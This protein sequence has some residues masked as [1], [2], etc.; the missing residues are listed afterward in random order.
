MTSDYPYMCEDLRLRVGLEGE[1]RSRP[2]AGHFAQVPSFNRDE[3]WTSL[4]IARPKEGVNGPVLFGFGLS[5]C[6]PAPLV[7]TL[8]SNLEVGLYQSNQRPDVNGYQGRHLE[9][10]S[11]P[12]LTPSYYP[13]PPHPVCTGRRRGVTSSIWLAALCP[14]N[15]TGVHGPWVAQTL[16]VLL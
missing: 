15:R 3:F 6:P 14:V 5:L 16:L 2:G 13:S 1:W 11:L 12:K 9:G 4:G 7:S 8:Q 10:R